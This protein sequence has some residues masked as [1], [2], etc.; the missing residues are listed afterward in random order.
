M[1]G[2]VDRINIRAT[3]I[4]NADNQSIIVPNREFITSNLVNWTHKDR[5]IRVKIELG[6]AYGTCPDR[7]AD[8][9]LTLARE[10]P[11]VLRNPVP[12]AS[13]ES[14]GDSALQFSLNVHVPDP[15][16]AGRVRHRLSTEIQRRFREAGIEIPKPGREVHVRTLPREWPL[17]LPSRPANV[18]FDQ[19]AQAP[20]APTVSTSAPEP[21][22]EEAIHRCVDE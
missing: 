2:K 15:S 13:L 16:L 3:T 19:Q 1:T 9:L 5:I 22:P 17:S 14:F 4:I 10:D 20:P 7:V 12:G 21:T 11:D 8:L 18:R 6:V